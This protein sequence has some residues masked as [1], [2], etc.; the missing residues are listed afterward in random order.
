M[1]GFSSCLTF[2]PPIFEPL[3]D[4]LV[5]FALSF[6]TY[7]PICYEPLDTNGK[8]QA[9]ITKDINSYD[10]LT[11]K[12]SVLYMEFTRTGN[13]KFSWVYLYLYTLSKYDTIRI[14]SLEFKF[15]DKNKIVRINKTIK[16]HQTESFFSVKDN[17]EMK[18][19]AYSGYA[20]MI[21]NKI[22]VYMQKIFNKKDE[23]IGKKIDLTLRINYSFDG[24]NKVTQE[25][26]YLV[27]VYKGK[28][29][30]PDWMYYLFPYM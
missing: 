10:E 28:L 11:N 2:A 9:S 25:I 16:L 19:A 29:G 6:E 5:Q 3:I 14:H 15:E 27:D 8:R 1:I 21:E 26:K 17:D 13:N 23:D 22:K 12:G 20:H 30:M 7:P 24:G 4:G 18:I